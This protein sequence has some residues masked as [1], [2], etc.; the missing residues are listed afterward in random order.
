MKLGQQLNTHRI[1]KWQAN[2]LIRLRVCTGWYAQAGL[3]LCLSHI[4]HWLKSHVAAHIC[5]LTHKFSQGFYLC[6]TSGAK[7]S[8]NK[9][10]VKWRNHSVV[11]RC[12]LTMPLSREILTLKICLL[13]QFL[14]KILNL[15]YKMDSSICPSILSTMCGYFVDTTPIT[16]LYWSFD[17][18]G[19]DAR[20]P[21][22]GGLSTTK[23]RVCQQQRRR[24]ACAYAQ[25]D[26]HLCYSLIGKYHI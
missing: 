1:L 14:R 8:E 20:K 15:Q 11:Y 9:S 6:K 18:L 22:F 26:Q 13:T 10:L 25:T 2:A 19:L 3:R 4:P 17:N 16:V 24:P 21:V 12:R 23:V 7:F 5:L